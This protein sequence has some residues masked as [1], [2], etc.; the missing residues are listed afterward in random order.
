MKSR[1]ICLFVLAI[2]FICLFAEPCFAARG[3]T[4]D[5]IKIGIINQKTGPASALGLPHSY[6]TIDYFEYI[7]EQGGINGRKIVVIFEDDQFE[8]PKSVALFNKLIH[9]DQVLTITN[10]GGTNQTIANNIPNTTAREFWE[11]YNPY[12]FSMGCTYEGQYQVMVDYI[13]NDLKAEKPRIGVVYAKKEYG[14]MG[15]EATRERAKAYGAD[16]ACELVLPTGAVDASS[17]ILALQQNNVDYVITCDILPPI[18]TF[19]KTAERYNYNPKAI[20][21]FNWAADPSIV[22]ACGNAAKNFIGANYVG[23][24]TDNAPG[25]NL[26]REL[27]K[28]YGR[29]LK[30]TSLYLNGAGAG[31]IFVEAFK[32]AGKNLNPDTLKEAFETLRNFETGGIFPPV[33]YTSKSHTPPEMVK[34]FKADVPNKTLAPITDWRKPREMKK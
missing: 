28:K 32:R 2:F 21:G 31:M 6:G 16:L 7:N 33:T 34:L 17:Q 23:S 5:S 11:P 19:L 4:K 26:M 9:R 20:F 29:D 18:V 10:C 27:A 13:F 24:W 15:L 1:K 8:A 12:L 30:L 14:K 3:V 25:I 22:E